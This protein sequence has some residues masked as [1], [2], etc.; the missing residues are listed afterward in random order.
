MPIRHTI[1]ETGQDGIKAGKLQARGHEEN[2]L[3]SEDILLF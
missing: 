2:A 3:K 1:K